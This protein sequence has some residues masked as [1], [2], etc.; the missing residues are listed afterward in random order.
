MNNEIYEYIRTVKGRKM[1]KNVKGELRRIGGEKIGLVL[2]TIHPRGLVEAPQILLGWSQCN[3]KAGDK[4]D[5]NAA[6]GI[7][8]QR[9]FKGT[10]ADVETP[11]EATVVLNRM[12]IRAAKCFK[13]ATL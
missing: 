3:R 13:G 2:A 12:A 11:R 9:A 4:F 10:P 7:A 5:K 6:L 8:R 1:V